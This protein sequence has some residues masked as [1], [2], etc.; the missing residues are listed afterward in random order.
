V[1]CFLRRSRLSLWLSSDWQ[2]ELEF[3]G[4]LILGVK[5]IGEVNS[6]NTA[7]GVDLNSQGLNVVSTV[8]SSREIRQVKLNLIPSLIKSHGHG[9]DER[10]DT[11]CALVVR[12]SESSAHALVVKDLH[13]EGEVFLQVLDDHDQE[14]ELDGKGLLGI[15]WACDV[16]SRNVGSHD[17]ENGR[18]NIRIS[19]SLDV[20]VSNVLVPDLKW[21]GSIGKM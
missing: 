11:S 9:A 15:D 2:E 12:C 6:A 13:F 10:L 17:L 19:Y 18:L 16:V 5:S 7:V 8:G 14:G 21:L 3:G 1:D 4:K 20:S